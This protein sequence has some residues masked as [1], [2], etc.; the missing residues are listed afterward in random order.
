M[1]FKGIVNVIFQQNRVG[2]SIQGSHVTSLL[3][4]KCQM[5]VIAFIVKHNFH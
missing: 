1:R 5:Q 2:S 3:I 4:L